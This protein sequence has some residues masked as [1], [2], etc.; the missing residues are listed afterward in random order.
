VSNSDQLL[1][2]A[3][4][5][6]AC[7][8]VSERRV[9]QLAAQG[10]IPRVEH[11]RYPLVESIRGWATWWRD[12]ISGKAEKISKDESRAK[13]MQAK[14]ESATVQAELLRASVY[15]RDEVEAVFGAALATVANHLAGLGGRVCSDVAPLT[16]PRLIAALIDR[17][18]RE[19]R[20][21]C[22]RELG[23]MAPPAADRRAR[24]A[25]AAEPKRRRVGGRKPRAPTRLV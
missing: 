24:D 16:E 7:F 11:G 20:E 3:K 6:A 9:Q 17:E 18:T 22:A 8:D 12:Q 19:I 23:R 2:P 14:A 21:R 1:V 25:P 5:L 10:V 4:V 13:L 15:R